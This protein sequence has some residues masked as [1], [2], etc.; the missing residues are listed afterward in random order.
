MAFLKLWKEVQLAA[1]MLAQA[2][3]YFLNIC[4]QRRDVFVFIPFATIFLP[5]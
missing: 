3:A 5:Q 1:G 4:V 2:Y